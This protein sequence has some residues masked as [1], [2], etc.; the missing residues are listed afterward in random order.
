MPPVVE[1]KLPRSFDLIQ[2]MF[3]VDQGGYLGQLSLS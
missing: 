1:H 2:R 3:K